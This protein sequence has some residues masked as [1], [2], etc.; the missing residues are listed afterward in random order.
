MFVTRVCEG[1]LGWARQTPERCQHHEIA[2]GHTFAHIKTAPLL[3]KQVL[4]QQP[5]QQTKGDNHTTFQ[6]MKVR[7]E[8]IEQGLEFFKTDLHRELPPVTAAYGSSGRVTPMATAGPKKPY[9]KASTIAPS[10]KN[11]QLMRQVSALGMEDPVFGTTEDGPKHPSNIFDDMS[12][13]DVPE[14]MRDLVSI[15]SDPTADV[16]GGIDQQAYHRSLGCLRRQSI[17]EDTEASGSEASLGLGAAAAAAPARLGAELL[18]EFEGD[19]KSSEESSASPP[20]GKS[21]MVYPPE[22]PEVPEE[23]L[24]KLN[25]SINSLPSLTLEDAMSG[26]PPSSPQSQR[27]LTVREEED[28][29][30]EKLNRS[31]Q[32][33]VS[34]TSK[35]SRMTETE[36]SERDESIAR[37]AKRLVCPRPNKHKHHHFGSQSASSLKYKHQY[38]APRAPQRQPTT[39]EDMLHVY[40][41]AM[42]KEFPMKGS[43]NSAA[44]P[45][46]PAKNFT[47][48]ALGRGDSI[49]QP[50]E[51]D[52]FAEW[53]GTVRG[54]TALNSSLL[55]AQP[56]NMHIPPSQPGIKGDEPLAKSRAMP[57]I[58]NLFP[59]D[60]AAVSKRSRARRAAKAAKS[61]S[62]S[63][64]DDSLRRRRQ[65]GDTTVSEMTPCTGMDTTTSVRAVRTQHTNSVFSMNS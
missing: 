2:Q 31:K 14:D 30:K 36:R 20:A 42:Q 29:V 41:R 15:A 11:R 5:F 35:T 8:S 55:V 32:S 1:H 7:N 37:M 47:P 61:S 13:G 3:Y 46:V 50:I 19:N 39:D 60:G 33:I 26:L 22:F 49:Y 12:L 38:D 6:T 63:S 48:S 56:E 45:P 59:V 9:L 65:C 4:H 43:N 40:S 53:N 21:Q 24:E 44:T 52:S 54:V 58:S 25:A 10:K 28:N 62:D 64:A 27:K 16:A 34:V 17:L 51:K 57:N 23:L 18:L